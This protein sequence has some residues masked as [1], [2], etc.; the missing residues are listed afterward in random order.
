M[1]KSSFK[2][3]YGYSGLGKQRFK[4]RHTKSY[5]ET[6]S[7]WPWWMGEITVKG[8]YKSFVMNLRAANV[9]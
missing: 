5:S 1:D 2:Q 9:N 7:N 4:G 6:V 8:N 3:G